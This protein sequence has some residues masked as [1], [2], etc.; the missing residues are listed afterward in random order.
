[1]KALEQ[2]PPP[3]P[4]PSPGDGAAAATTAGDLTDKTQLSKLLFGQ[5]TRGGLAD[6]HFVAITLREAEVRRENPSHP[7]RGGLH[8]RLGGLHPARSR[9]Q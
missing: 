5:S 8:P 6:R 4:S 7:R 1:M 3:S 9:S 2:Q